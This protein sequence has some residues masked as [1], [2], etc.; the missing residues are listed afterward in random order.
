MTSFLYAKCTILALRTTQGK[1]G[2][3]ILTLKEKHPLLFQ[4]FLHGA[5]QLG[6]MGCEETLREFSSIFQDAIQAVHNVQA[7]T[8]QN[9]PPYTGYT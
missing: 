5:A 3:F 8:F 7:Y 4:S 9:Q 2:T 1:G 6:S